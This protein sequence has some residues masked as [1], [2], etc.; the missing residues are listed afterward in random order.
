MRENACYA[1]EAVVVSSARG[2]HEPHAAQLSQRTRHCGALCK[3]LRRAERRNS[4]TRGA[5]R[6]QKIHELRSTE[7]TLNRTSVE[8]F[9]YRTIHV[10]VLHLD[11]ESH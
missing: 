2:P 9:L 7:N 3:A 5:S 10:E 8:T 1:Q 11:T 4:A 6:L